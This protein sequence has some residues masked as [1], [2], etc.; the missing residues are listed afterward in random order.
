MNRSDFTFATV[1]TQAT[2]A[3]ASNMSAARP[4]LP[5]GFSAGTSAGAGF[6]AA[7][8]QVQGDVANF[9]DNGGGSFTGQS[10]GTLTADGAALRARLAASAPDSSGVIDGDMANS[11]IDGDLQQ[12]F[13]ASIRPYAEEAGRKLGVSPDLV[14]AHAALESGWGQRPLR[15]GT[16]D[17]NNLFGIKAGGSWQGDVAANVTT[18]YEHGA[19]LKKVEKFRSYPDQASAFRDYATLLA[20]NPRYRNALN[21]GA[22]AHA[23]A[24]GLAKGGYA[25]DPAYAQKLSKLA[26]RVASGS[27]PVK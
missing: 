1:P 19:A 18:E 11:G 2:A 25:T 7:F 10:D 16:A 14:A 5:A 13:L 15:N 9:I 3:T 23:F 6:S 4:A 27:V 20:D 17:S 21:T 12:Q 22:D 24:T 8:R 26:A